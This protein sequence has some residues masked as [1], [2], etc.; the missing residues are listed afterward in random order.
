LQS[1]Q[2]AEVRAD[3]T[4]CLNFTSNDYNALA[5]SD[6]MIACAKKSLDERGYGMASAPLMS[7]QQDIHKLLEDELAE[8]HGT[9]KAVVYPSGY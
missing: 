4:D 8:F 7:G 5:A 1:K 2:K 6:E 3:D 9:D